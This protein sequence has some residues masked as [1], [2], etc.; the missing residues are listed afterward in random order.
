MTSLFSK[1]EDLNKSAIN[2]GYLILQTFV[3]LKTDKLSI[4]EIMKL[5]RKKQS[6]SIRSFYHGIIFLYSVDLIKFDEPF[7]QI[8]NNDNSKIIQ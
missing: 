4:F 2:I 5:L 7:I 1:D 6:V 8:I 3:T